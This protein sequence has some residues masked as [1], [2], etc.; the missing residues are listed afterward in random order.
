MDVRT[1]M[2]LI[3]IIQPYDI[4]C[5]NSAMECVSIC[6]MRWIINDINYKKSRYQIKC[7]LW[8]FFQ[9]QQKPSGDTS[10]GYVQDDQLISDVIII[11]VWV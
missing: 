6:L 3:A 1:N 9:K 4:S 7:N 8:L 2:I 11:T 5:R 10:G